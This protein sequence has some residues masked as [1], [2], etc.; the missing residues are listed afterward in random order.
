MMATKSSAQT[1]SVKVVSRLLS[2]L[3]LSLDR[4]S[5][6]ECLSSICEN[7]IKLFTAEACL[8]FLHDRGDDIVYVAASLGNYLDNPDELRL[9]VGKGIAGWVALHQEA[10]LLNDVTRDERYHQEVS[11]LSV[12]IQPRSML[13][14]PLAALGSFIGVMEVV[15][16]KKGFMKAD[17]ERL[18]PI[19]NIAALAIPRETD[20]SFAKLAEVCVRFLEEKDKYTHGHSLRVMKYCMVIADEIGMPKAQKAELRLCA[21]LHDIGKVII[22]D[23]LLSKAGPL[24]KQELHTIRLHP[25]IGFNIVDRISKNLSRKILSHH[26]KYD[27][28][29]YPKRLRGEEIPLVSRLIAIA[30]ALD[31]ITTERPYRRASDIEFAIKE[32]KANAG[33][34]FDPKLVAALVR[35]YEKGKLKLVK[36]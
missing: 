22:R 20:E 26:E 5:L 33:T 36:V 1:R 21:L 10:L 15:S 4:V 12:R 28:T 23:S 3:I 31:A 9:P 30:D 11:N 14:F 29:G 27:G 13:A 32:I 19:A 24:T 16:S 34:Q 6:Q 8:I 7:I 35:A 17:I 25:T 2:D 18:H